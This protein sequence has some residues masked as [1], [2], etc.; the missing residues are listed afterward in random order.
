MGIVIQKSRIDDIEERKKPGSDVPAG[1]T[2]R[3]TLDGVAIVIDLNEA[4]SQRLIRDFDKYRKAG[5]RVKGS[6]GRVRSRR[7]LAEIRDWARERGYPVKDMG[8]VAASIVAE[9]EAAH[10]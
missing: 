5:R 2:H 8:R 10:S 4:N 9:Y 7:S 3:L 6:S 1:H